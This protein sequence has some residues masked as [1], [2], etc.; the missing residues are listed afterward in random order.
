MI[1][2]NEVVRVDVD[3]GSVET[4]AGARIGDTE[5]RIKSLYAGR[6]TV[7][8][9]KYTDGHYLTVVPADKADSAFRLIFETDG[10]RVTRYRSGKRPQVEYVE[11]CG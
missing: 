4:S 6:I 3:S 8:P 1:E 9:H 11:R 5:D 10:N 7:G 2:R